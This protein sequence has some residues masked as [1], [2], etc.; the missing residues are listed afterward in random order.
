MKV[1][2][3]LTAA[4][5]GT[6]LFTSCKK[7][8]DQVNENKGN[9]SLIFGDSV[10]VKGN[11]DY[12][13]DQNLPKW[14]GNDGGTLS[15]QATTLT[16]ESAS[17]SVSKFLQGSIAN[18][19]VGDIGTS[20]SASNTYG[21]IRLINVFI[22]DCRAGT[23]PAATKNRFIAQ[24]YFFRA[25]RYFSLVRVYGGVPLVLTPLSSVG[26]ENKLADLL[27]RNKTSECIKQISDDLDTCIKYLP[28]KWPNSADWGRIT[29]GAAAAFKSRVLL[30]WASPQFNPTDDKTRWQAAYDASNQAVNLLTKG[31]FGL[32]TSTALS[33]ATGSTNPYQNMWFTEVNNPEAVMISGYNTS[34]GDQTRNSNGYDASVRPS[35]LGGS[36][37]SSQPTW[38]FVKLYPMKDGKN[39]GDPTSAYAYSDQKFWKNRDP[40]FNAT[41]AFNGTT[42]PTL[43]NNSYKLWTYLYYTKPDSSASKTTEISGRTT[44]GFYL[45]KATK[46]D[47]NATDLLY[48]GTDWME[49]RYAEVLLNQAEAAAE[50][51]TPNTTVAYDNLKAIRARAQVEKGADGMYGLTPGLT[52]QPLID[53]IMLERAIE[54]A[55][56]G[57]RFWDLQRRN[58]VG[59]VMNA[60]GKRVGLVITLRNTGTNNDYIAS[61]RDAANLDDLYSKTFTP[62]STAH[63][64]FVSLDDVYKTGIAWDQTK[65]S[66]FP[67]PPATITNDPNIQQNVAW[68]GTFDP[69]Q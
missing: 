38:N 9:A 4:F 39:P 36:G 53:A 60:I 47:A 42:W 56:E 49:I 32:F 19:D 30:T 23:L 52:G 26:D 57:K 16:D 45:R 1:N 20:N 6:L 33:T 40:R 48:S 8:L 15:A 64:S 7:V 43:G 12:I 25:F 37:G 55:Y 2:K 27:P 28:V 63:K 18:S 66:F 51:A 62:I 14:N 34:Q 67:I 59:P 54:F 35:Y 10:L 61:T 22:R 46:A 41:I 29:S 69:L 44:S 24:A 21:K 13:Y 31:G 5:I 3:L 11:I 17:S 58:L 65:Y 68:G 50:L